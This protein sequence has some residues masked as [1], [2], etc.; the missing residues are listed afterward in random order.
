M[1]LVL[2]LLTVFGISVQFNSSSSLYDDMKADSMEKEMIMNSVE[3][4]EPLVEIKDVK[5]ITISSKDGLPITADIYEVENSSKPTILL[6]HQAG[7]SRGE[8]VEIAPKLNKLGYSCIAID[9][10]SGREVNGVVNETH[11][12]AKKENKKTEFVDAIDDLRATIEYALEEFGS[13]EVILWGSSYS[14]SLVL[15]L[16]NE[17]TENVSAILSFAPGE[18]FTYQGK[19]IEEYASSLSK[20]VF[21][22]SAKNEYKNWKSIFDK[23]STDTKT[24]FLPS[25]KGYHG[26][27]ALWEKN[28]GNEEYWENV[29]GFLNK[30]QIK[31]K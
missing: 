12:A 1:K 28:E 4:V 2:M 10:R 27:K 9:Q 19:K 8:Y 15:I 23:I 29:I 14:S 21:I 11:L 20:P 22:T 3:E 26:S 5:T 6:F 17:Y 16:G 24:K 18:Y 7:Y 25:D 30:I 13:K 31:G